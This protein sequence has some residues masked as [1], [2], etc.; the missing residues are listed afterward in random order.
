MSGSAYM[1]SRR[2]GIAFSEIEAIRNSL[3]EAALTALALEVVARVANNLRDLPPSEVTPTSEE[4]DDMCAALL[5]PDRRAAIAQV[6]RARR[7]G[8]SY[9]TLCLGYLSGAARRLGDWWDD[10]R[11]PFQEVTIAA[12]RIYALLR[13]LRL[14][15]MT[16]LPDLRRAAVFAAVPGEDHTLGI[17]IAADL[18]RN[19]GWDVELFV[20][21]S[22]DDLVRELEVRQSVIIGL[23]ASG[24]RSLPALIKLIVALRISC[25]RARILV[26]GN[27]ATT[28]FN[29]VGLTGADAAATDFEGALV[30]LERL[31]MLPSARQI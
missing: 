10:D 8:A 22:H 7:K 5:S 21:R 20:G 26:C 18:A 13:I 19:R 11:V 17:T 28:S 23:S 16:P 6:V 30:E 24:K 9:E 25:P 2:L 3:P 15:R 14:E 1:D 29:L 27:I 12:G 31:A 4:I